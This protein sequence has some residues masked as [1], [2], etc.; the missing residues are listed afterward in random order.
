LYCRDPEAE[1]VETQMEKVAR[2]E[3]NWVQNASNRPSQKDGFERR[4]EKLNQQHML[5]QQQQQQ[6]NGGGRQ[7]R[8]RHGRPR[9]G[10]TAPSALAPVGGSHYG[11]TKQS[12]QASPRQIYGQQKPA[13]AEAYL[14]GRQAPYNALG[15]GAPGRKGR[16]AQV[17]GGKPTKKNREAGGGAAAGGRGGSKSAVDKTMANMDMGSLMYIL[18]SQA[19]STRIRQLKEQMRQQ[20]SINA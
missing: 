8:S 3:N 7:G 10:K 15:L 20:R 17:E 6:A 5:R 9:P 4:L 16:G 13:A 18:G 11:Y 14:P 19:S 1:P 12:L 2:L